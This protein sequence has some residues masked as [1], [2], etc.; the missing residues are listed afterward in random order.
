VDKVG[1][2]EWQGYAY[3]PVTEAIIN[4]GWAGPFLVFAA[5]SVLLNA[6][7]AAG[8]AYFGLYLVAFSSV[9]DFSRGE[10]GGWAY[11]MF[12]VFV[13]YASACWLSGGPLR[14]RESMTG[15]GGVS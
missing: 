15:G 9:P 11:H 5:I 14:D 1:T 2:S 7:I 12:V 3:T 10:F 4:F 6:L 13:A 8:R